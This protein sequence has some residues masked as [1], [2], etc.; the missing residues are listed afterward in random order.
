MKHKFVGKE[1]K[2]EIFN[3]IETHHYSHLVPSHAAIR[4]IYG[5]MEDDEIIAGILWSI[6]ASSWKE[7]V[8]ELS[9]LCRLPNTKPFLTSLISQSIKDIKKDKKYDLLISYSDTTHDHHGGVYQ[10]SSWNFSGIRKG[11]LDAFLIDGVR[12]PCRTCNHR[13]GTS[14]IKLVEILG[15]EGIEVIPQ[16]SKDKYLYWKALNKNGLKKAERLGLKTLP[17][18]KPDLKS[19]T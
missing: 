19:T 10:A 1:Y 11:R 2:K 6:P 5:L 13:Y 14:S 15:K 9:R 17:Y 3:L 8:L 12:V 18:L 7:P 16:K 4:K